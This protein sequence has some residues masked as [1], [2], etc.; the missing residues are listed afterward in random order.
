MDSI[1]GLYTTSGSG[2]SEVDNLGIKKGGDIFSDSPERL[3]LVGK[4]GKSTTPQK[5]TQADKTNGKIPAGRD[6]GDNK[7]GTI[8]LGNVA[9]A[10]LDDEA[11]NLG[12]LNERL[13]NVKADKVPYVSIKSTLKGTG[14]NYNSDG[15]TGVNSI[16]I[17]P[18]AV[19][20]DE[21][22]TV[23]GHDARVNSKNTIAI[24][25]SA[26]NTKLENGSGSVFIGRNAGKD[27]GIIDHQGAK[28]W[29]SVYIGQ[30]AG[31]GS[32][33]D[34]N[35]YLG[36]NT[37]FQ[38][39]GSQNIF[40]GD[41]ARNLKD[42][43]K[44]DDLS[45]HTQGNRNIAIGNQYVHD[46]AKVNTDSNAIDDTIT[47]GTGT[48]VGADR[49][50]A[51]GSA[52]DYRN[53]GENYIATV[54]N[55]ANSIALG[56]GILV[57]SKNGVAI[58]FGS[59]ISDEKI[60]DAVALGSYSQATTK[61]LDA[62]TKKSVY[63]VD[64][65]EVAATAASTKGAISV[66]STI[67]GLDE[68]GNK[69][70]PFTRQITNI[71][72]GTTNT[73]AVNVAQLKAGLSGKADLD[74]GNLD[75]K[76]GNPNNANET[77]TDVWKEK[78]GINEK[79]DKSDI[80]NLTTNI[81]NKADKSDLTNLAKTDLSNITNNGETK[82][83][84]LAKGSVEVEA[85]KNQDIVKVEKTTGT[86]KDTYTVSV[87]ADKL[88]KNNTFITSLGDNFAKKDASN[89]ADNKADWETALG[90]KEYVKS[91]DSTD[92][93]IEVNSNDKQNP[94]L[95]LNTTNLAGD[96]TF[97]ENI[98]GNQNFTTKLGDTFVTK[99]NLAGDL[100]GYTKLDGSNLATIAKNTWRTALGVSDG[101]IKTLAQNSVDV[102]AK[103]DSK[104]TV[105]NKG[106]VDGKQTFEVGVD[107]TGLNGTAYT[108]AAGEN[109]T[110][111]DKSGKVKYSLN[112]DLKNITSIENGGK[113]YTFG[114]TNL[115]DT[116]VITNKELTTKVTEAV[117]S[118]KFA[119]KGDDNTEGEVK[120]S[121]GLSVV[122]KTDSGIT[123]TAENGK[124]TLSLNADKVK[125]IAG[126]DGLDDKLA[127]KANLDASNL[128]DDANK[129]K[130]KTALGIKDLNT[131]QLFT[132]KADES[133]EGATIGANGTLNFFGDKNVIASSDASGIKYT[134]NKDLKDINSITT[135]NKG[136]LT[137][138]AGDNKQYTFGDTN[139]VDTSVITNKELTTKV[140]E[141]V[142]ASKFA[143]KGDDNT[144]GEVKLSEGLSVVG[145]ANSELSDKNIGVVAVNNSLQV[146]LAKNLLGLESAEFKKGAD[147]TTVSAEE[148]VST[149][150]TLKVTD[151]N[152]KTVAEIDNTQIK[153][154]DGKAVTN[155][156]SAINNLYTTTKGLTSD[157]AL[158]VKYDSA[159]K[160]EITLGGIGATDKVAIKNL[161]SAGDIN[162]A[163]NEFN[164][165]NAGDLKT[166][167]N[168]VSSSITNKIDIG[169]FTSLSVTANGG[170]AK[171]EIK[172]NENIDFTAK[173]GIKVAYDKNVNKFTFS[174]DI[175]SIAGNIADNDAFS[176]KYAMLDGRN[177][178][179][180][181]GFKQDVWREA[182][183][184]T[185]ANIA[186]I[187]EEGKDISITKNSNNNKYTIAYKGTGSGTGTGGI[188]ENEVRTIIKKYIGGDNIDSSIGST[189][190][191]VTHNVS[192][193][194][195]TNNK[196]IIAA[197]NKI[198]QEGIGF[199]HVNG[200]KLNLNAS[201]KSENDSSAEGKNAIAIG[202]KSRA[203]GNNSISIGL[204]SQAS[205][206]ENA[207]AIGTGSQANGYKSIAIGVGNVVTGQN[208][209]AFGDPSIVAGIDSYSVGN[210]NE[211]N[212]ND[213]FVLGNK[214][215]VG[216]DMQ[217]AVVLGSGSTA[218]DKATQESRATVNGITY[219]GFKGQ[220]ASDGM[221]LSVGAK[222]AERQI[223]NVAAGKI[224]KDSTDAVNGSQ[225]YATNKIIG[226]VANSVKNVIGGNAKVNNNGEISASDIG[227][228]GQNNINN[229]IAY[230]NKR[231]KSG[232]S[233]IDI[234]A[235]EGSVL[236]SVSKGSNS[237][238]IGAGS[239]D[240]K[241]KNVVSVGNA[242]KGLNR[243]ITNVAPGKYG[244]DA[245]NMN[246]L[247]G[248]AGG[249]SKQINDVKKKSSAGIAGAVALGMLPQSNIPGDALV[250][251]GTG[252]HDSESAVALG[253]SKTSDNARWIF[254]G[255]VSY[256]S[257][258]EVT[259]GASVGFHF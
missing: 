1:T 179:A 72:A 192:K 229:A 230:I 209:G 160:K 168:G 112:K 98:A 119:I 148:G 200:E 246:Q 129:N 2:A 191:I 17:G 65:A 176:R 19:A 85:A 121:E 127:A 107:L 256:D 225:L 211:I 194:E 198:N 208:S 109:L 66:G 233:Y 131:K 90:L 215:R 12:Q 29:G 15:A 239:S 240:D 187:F 181:Q 235:P 141:A 10:E 218:V 110:V 210:N 60:T 91:V 134:L 100:A 238:A 122:G 28:N 157:N 114:D 79:A 145:G 104:V 204:E 53:K 126:V 62:G 41:G 236:P 44:Y 67:E 165:V 4:D 26:G 75:N 142:G 43:E 97:V 87:N 113:T 254:K 32:E 33:G 68:K 73:D 190:N 182:L 21:N 46:P 59:G 71:A 74:A 185:D 23:I 133:T 8:R 139:L 250:S 247:Y 144:E 244:T 9:K 163:K 106:V 118:S 130:W 84:N 30:D 38:H 151:S 128:T 61:A 171:D 154:A 45:L 231:N 161:A 178:K 77:Y 37:G 120:L 96:K 206:G 117:G 50:I 64:D 152:G 111:E 124:F 16:A 197:I 132:A 99:T 36:S 70:K 258:D 252:Y 193:Q 140:T 237:I 51:I 27:S 149:T 7:D 63:L 221:I 241:R 39:N 216:A 48:R 228:T 13:Q 147:T 76:T 5:Y 155:I 105:A 159:D 103:K 243:T 52:Y 217:G 257:Q 251:I 20:M 31:H 24:G 83:K 172:A 196:N 214:V 249:L 220:A 14:S 125:E 232:N 207:I 156:N 227:G 115:V 49:A 146:K 116:S 88:A 58:G 56:S 222:N 180:A 94:K 177:L 199:V 81:N 102:V 123:T 203:V 55:G 245:V 248:V 175:N 6:V 226:N 47:I 259:A 22:A 255:G 219:D 186:N 86:D 137:I 34:G 184:L 169:D 201:G 69:V 25:A 212:S 57:N 42:G 136:T 158:A 195:T 164:A 242:T 223:K 82:I 101:D 183:G 11:V 162:D 174:A 92:N 135:E 166:A 3:S 40:L 108:F 188:T 167:L 35:L 89:I 54:A 95:S 224:L 153:D 150:K 234:D 143:I 213:T 202:P 170:S 80:T 93:F 18:K 205:G 189:D 173:D 253:I 138:N 78:L